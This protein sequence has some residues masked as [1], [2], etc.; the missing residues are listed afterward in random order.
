MQVFSM[1]NRAKDDKIYQH[2]HSENH[3]GLDVSVM[4]IDKCNTEHSLREKEA[5]WA[6]RLNTISPKGLNVEEYVYL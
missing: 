6:Y 1:A 3:C 2:F 4:I 5:Q